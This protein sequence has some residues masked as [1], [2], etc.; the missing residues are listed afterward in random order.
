MTGGPQDALPMTVTLTTRK[1]ARFQQFWAVLD[2]LAG[3]RLDQL[4][5][6]S[7]VARLQDLMEGDDLMVGTPAP[8]DDLCLVLDLTPACADWLAD[9][10]AA[11][12]ADIAKTFAAPADP[13]VPNSIGGL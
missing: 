1:T 12:P 4:P 11:L 13:A 8:D 6:A 2:G 9:L 10:L 3:P 5:V 7:F